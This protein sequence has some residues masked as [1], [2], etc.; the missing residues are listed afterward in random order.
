[1]KLVVAAATFVAVLSTSRVEAEP[2]AITGGSIHWNRISGSAEL[3]GE[4]FI[5][6]AAMGA[7]Q[8]LFGPWVT[9]LPCAP[10]AVIDTSGYFGGFGLSGDKLNGIDV[11]FDA[12]TELRFGGGSL[13]APFGDALTATIVTTTASA[14]GFVGLSPGE[15]ALYQ[16]FTVNPGTL[17]LTLGRGS[18]NDPW[19]YQAAVYDFNPPDPVPEPT[20]MVLIGTGLAGIWYRRRALNQRG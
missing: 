6:T 17:T 3:I 9:C 1:V 11:P 18:A 2:I 20:T 5:Y 10:G 19:T 8:G 14:R 15:P 7:P 13:I 12:P 16:F 4:N